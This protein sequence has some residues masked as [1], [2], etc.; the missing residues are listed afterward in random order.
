MYTDVISNCSN[1]A[2]RVSAEV[3]DPFPLLQYKQGDKPRLLYTRE[4]MD[5]EPPMLAR[6]WANFA[7]PVPAETTRGGGSTRPDAGD[8]GR[9]STLLSVFPLGILTCFP[10]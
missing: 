9:L 7:M 10:F 2:S 3:A 1:F 6:T 5:G 4:L 8:K